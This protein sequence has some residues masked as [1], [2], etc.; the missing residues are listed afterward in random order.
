MARVGPP[1]IAD[2]NPVESFWNM[3][4]GLCVR[5]FEVLK[6]LAILSCVRIGKVNLVGGVVKAPLRAHHV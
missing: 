6:R 3:T 1:I 5:W 2:S 4:Y